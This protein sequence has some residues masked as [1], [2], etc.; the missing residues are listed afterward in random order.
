MKILILIT[1]VLV[2]FSAH[3]VHYS[4]T[5]FEKV[6]EDYIVVTLSSPRRMATVNFRTVCDT[7][8]GL[9]SAN[10]SVRLYDGLR[11]N[12]PGEYTDTILL[13]CDKQS[14]IERKE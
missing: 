6:A 14:C 9:D 11:A 12:P 2:S 1:L 5:G 7:T 4:N 13:Q 10:C 8:Y 3:G